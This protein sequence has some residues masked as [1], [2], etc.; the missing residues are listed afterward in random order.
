MTELFGADFGRVRAD[1]RFFYK[2]YGAVRKTYRKSAAVNY[3]ERVQEFVVPRI[4]QYGAT[5]LMLWSRRPCSKVFDHQK[6]N[7]VRYN[8]VALNFPSQPPRY[9]RTLLYLQILFQIVGKGLFMRRH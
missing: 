8:A 9:S 1:A 7:V 6:R 2:T 3:K 5:V 4:T